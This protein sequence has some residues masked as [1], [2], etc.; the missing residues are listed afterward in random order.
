[1]DTFAERANV[2]YQYCLL[3][4]EN[5]VPF[6]ICRRQMEVFRFRLVPFGIYIYVYIHIETAT[7][8]HIHIYIYLQIYISIY[9]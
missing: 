9:L 7:Y 2:S 8:I 5:K 1:M 4:K 6:Y 3:N